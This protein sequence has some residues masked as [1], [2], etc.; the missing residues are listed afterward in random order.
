ME[1]PALEFHAPFSVLRNQETVA[2]AQVL[3]PFPVNKILHRVLEPE[4]FLR[5]KSPVDPESLLADEP[6]NL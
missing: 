1:T 3:E 2:P 5:R 4:G 6:F